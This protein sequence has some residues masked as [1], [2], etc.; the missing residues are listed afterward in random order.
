VAMLEQVGFPMERTAEEAWPD[1][2]GWRV[3]YE[4]VAY[5][6]ADRLTAPPAPWT[7]ARRHLRS[8]P[9]APNRPPQRS[10]STLASLRPDVVVA[11]NARRH[12]GSGRGAD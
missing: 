1:F 8:G 6:L 2:R 12:G 11:P 3:N 7:G 5:R 4:T 10:P 9:V